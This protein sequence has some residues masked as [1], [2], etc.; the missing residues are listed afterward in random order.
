MGTQLTMFDVEDMTGKP[1]RKKSKTYEEFVEKFKPKKTTDDCYTPPAV[2]DAVLDYVKD[3]ADIKGRPI[4]RPFY[5]GGD[6]E[7]YDYPANC[8]VVDNPPFSILSG[9]KNF[10][11]SRGIDF[12][13]FAPSLTLFSPHDITFIVANADVTYENGAVVRT[14]FITN[15]TPEYRII[16]DPRLREIIDAAQGRFEKKV[17]AAKKVIKY[18]NRLV[19]GA[20]LQR[21]CYYGV[22][23]L[24][25]K[26][27]ET[28]PVRKL[29]NMAGAL[30]GSGFLLSRSATAR[31]MK[32]EEE[33]RRMKARRMKAEESI[34][35]ELSPREMEI[36][37]NLDN[38]AESDE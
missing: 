31:R 14:G 32:A 26:K 3:L 18:P 28:V 15:L 13:L 6:Y 35:I 36:I 19:T 7:N 37:D 38:T 5:P 1:A 27:S 12:F 10:Y 25:I 33:A 2:Y 30:Y 8:V 11:L 23:P 17:A 20:H 22:P 9:I 21:V 24:F 16:V 29:D 34:S 4:V